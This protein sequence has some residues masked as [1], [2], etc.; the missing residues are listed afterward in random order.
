MSAQLVSVV[1]PVYNGA[2]FLRTAVDSV[3]AQTYAPVEVI[4]VD[5]GSTDD[6]PTVLASYGDRVHVIRQRNSGVSAARNVGVRQA[7]GAFVAFLDQDDWWLP[8]KVGRQVEQFATD[9]DLGL[10]HTDVA[11]YDEPSAAYVEGW[12]DA[13]GPGQLVGRCY[14]RLL[15][16]NA[17]SNSSVM[18][19]KAVLDAVGGFNTEIRRNT[20]QDYDLWLRVARRSAFGY[21]PDRLTVYRLHPGQGMWHTRNSLAEELHMLERVVGKAGLLATPAMRQRLVALL[22]GLSVAYLD[23]SDGRNA[24][25]C[26]TRSLRVRWTCRNTLLLGLTFLPPAWADRSRRLW[27]Q[28][29]ALAGRSR[30]NGVPKWTKVGTPQAGLSERV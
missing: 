12:L 11:Y 16:G 29:W 25:A 13:S 3:L 2:R 15:Q 27:T 1:I 22:N 7:A 10:V 9:A 18:V 5:D 19:R 6:S 14:D 28:V 4:A 30:D 17:I 26:L 8:T 20:I 23:A 24:R 21:L